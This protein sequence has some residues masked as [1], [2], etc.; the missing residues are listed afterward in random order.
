MFTI[1]ER[2]KKLLEERVATSR[3]LGSDN[4]LVL[5]GGGNTSVK[6]KVRSL[7]SKDVSALFVKGSGSD[8][9]TVNIEDFTAVNLDN[10]NEARVLANMSDEDM[11]SFIKGCMLDTSQSFPSVEI[12]I[13]AFVNWD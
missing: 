11:S 2:E 9:A 10:L 3:S 5:H 7:T 13:H 4:S 8:L 6:L 1:P 12:F